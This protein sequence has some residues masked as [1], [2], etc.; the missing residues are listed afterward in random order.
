MSIPSF[1]AISKLPIQNR[2]VWV[3]RDDLQNNFYPGNKFRKLHSVL[4]KLNSNSTSYSRVVSFGGCQSNMMLAVATMAHQYRLK[5]D[6][7]TPYISP[8][9]RSNF[10]N[11]FVSFFDLG[12][13]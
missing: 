4:K 10:G 2:V 9:S 5:F 8:S 1:S 11:M 7:Y 3:K 6:Y 13:C 12:I